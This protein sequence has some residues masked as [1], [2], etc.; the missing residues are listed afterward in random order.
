VW[1]LFDIKKKQDKNIPIKK[2]D[3]NKVKLAKLKGN[4]IFLKNKTKEVNDNNEV[5]EKEYVSNAITKSMVNIPDSVYMVNKIGKENVKQTRENL[6]KGK[7]K[8]KNAQREIKNKRMRSKSVKNSDRKIKTIKRTQKVNKPSTKVAVK[9]NHK[10]IQM[11]KSAAKKTVN[12]MKLSIK[13]TIVL[14]K[15]IIVG[16]KALISLILAG[17]WIAV[18][19]ILLISLIALFSSSIFGIFFANENINS[20]SGT[21]NDIVLE[22][23]MD[24]LDK[25]NLI[26]SENYHDKYVLN[27]NRADWKDILALYSVRVY[28]NEKEILTLDDEKISALKGVFGDMN[29][30]DFNIK[31]EYVEEIKIIDDVEI[32][33]QVEK[34]VL[35]IDINSKTVEDMI[36]QYNFSSVQI[37]QL[38]ELLDEKYDNLWL[39]VIYGITNKENDIVKV[40]LL[41]V[42]NIGGETYWKWYGYSERVD[43]CACFVSWCAEQCGYIENNLIPKFSYCP[44]AVDWFKICSLWGDNDYIPKQGDIIFFNWVETDTG[45]RNGIADHV[46]I[47]EK[48]ENDRVYT[49][50]GNS[51]DMCMKKDYDINSLDILGYGISVY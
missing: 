46:G 4:I 18:V 26:K 43:W 20:E 34:S 48:V 49:I 23:N 30:I 19:I 1:N 16:T 7:E 10:I 13:S 47:V 33:E 22:L 51:D 8:I 25:V 21:I 45:E 41:Q 2:F 11:T 17:G 5:S 28:N 42:G 38:N 37:E 39:P 35:Y 24:M 31:T 15:A 9:T 44:D 3:R 36:L 14:T 40:A 50:E 29:S 27:V 6:Y 32:I 12:I